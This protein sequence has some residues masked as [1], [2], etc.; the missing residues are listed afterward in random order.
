MIDMEEEPTDLYGD[1][2]MK[3][4]A[5]QSGALFAV[6]KVEDKKIRFQIDCCAKVN[7]LQ[8][9]LTAAAQFQPAQVH[10][11]FMP[12]SQ[13]RTNCSHISSLSLMTTIHLY[14]GDEPWN[15]MTRL[16]GT[17]IIWKT[18]YV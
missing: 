4:S 9:N 1:A 14:W 7:I 5:D 18:L 11:C 12:K 3:M 13:R 16:K 15:S 6:M 17:T 10:A 8:K 2:L